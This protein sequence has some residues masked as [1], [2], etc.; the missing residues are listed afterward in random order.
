MHWWHIFLK[1]FIYISVLVSENA[2]D[3]SR[4][5]YNISNHSFFL[6]YWLL[7]DRLSFLSH[8]WARSTTSDIIIWL[9]H[10][11]LYLHYPIIAVILSLSVK[12]YVQLLSSTSLIPLSNYC[13]YRYNSMSRSV[14]LCLPIREKKFSFILSTGASYL[15]WHAYNNFYF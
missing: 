8:W 15:W 6:M 12:L 5:Y 2:S 9:F 1:Y 11:H 10:L 13:C 7:H 3:T 14:F 4:N